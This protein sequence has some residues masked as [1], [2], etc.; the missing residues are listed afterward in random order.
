MNIERRVGKLEEGLG[1]RERPRK[2][3]KIKLFILVEKDWDT[4]EIIEY[5]PTQ[6]WI[7]NAYKKAQE[8]NPKQSHCFLYCKDKDQLKAIPKVE[9]EEHCWFLERV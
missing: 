4:G 5:M 6:E 9:G 1:M 7:D 8:K 3:A 2:R